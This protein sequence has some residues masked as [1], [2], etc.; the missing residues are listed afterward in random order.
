MTKKINDICT[1]FQYNI[2]KTVGGDGGKAEGEEVIIRICG[3][4][5]SE[6]LLSNMTW[7]GK[8]GKKEKKKIAFKS[9]EQI[10]QLFC[11]LS[12]AADKRFDQKDCHQV[13]VYKVLKYAYKKA[14]VTENVKEKSVE[15][16]EEVEVDNEII[17][18]ISDESTGAINTP[19]Q[20]VS[21]NHMN[22][23]PFLQ[24]QPP[25][26]LQ[27]Q[28][29]PSVSG[30]NYHQNGVHHIIPHSTTQFVNKNL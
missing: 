21:T 8:C 29:V 27:Y 18:V 28:S 15:T 7:T 4:M 16:I 25:H 26:R 10:I 2:F 20:A 30:Q 14:P 6:Q 17:Y 24:Y 11:N 1:F 23:M 19:C 22:S 9:F 12:S 5:F 13:F 3:Y